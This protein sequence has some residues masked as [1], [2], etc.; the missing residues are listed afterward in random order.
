MEEEDFT[1]V[2]RDIT[3]G[4]EELK[5]VTKLMKLMY[6]AEQMTQKLT[7]DGAPL[8]KPN[9]GSPSS[10]KKQNTHA[11]FGGPHKKN[12][13]TKATCQDKPPHEWVN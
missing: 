6:K 10:R 5:Y 11:P 9:Q 4:T 8:K 12:M 1:M 13:C 2:P 7:S 3:N